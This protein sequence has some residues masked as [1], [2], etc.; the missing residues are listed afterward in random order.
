MT[1]EAG[2][3]GSARLRPRAR[4]ISLIGEELISDEPVALVELVKNSFDADASRVIVKFEGDDPYQPSRIVVQDDGIGMSLDTVLGAWFEPGTIAKRGITSSPGGRP[5]QGAKGIGRFATARLANSLV[6]ESVTSDERLGVYVLLDWGVFDDQSYLDDISVEYETRVIP[7]L[8]RGTRLTLEGLRKS[9]TET[10]Y[11]ALHARLSRLI[12]PFDEVRDFA[13]ELI[14]PAFSDLSGRVAPPELVL[15]PKYELRGRLNEVGEFQGEIRL[16]GQLGR[17]IPLWRIKSRTDAPACG[18]FEVEIRAWDR[19][20]DALVPFAESLSLSV[21]EVRR[22]L[23]AYCGISVYRNGFRVHP[24][25]ESGDD[26]LN[27]DIRSRLSPASRLANNQVI[28]AIRLSREDNPGLRDRSNRE[29]MVHNSEF[30]SLIDWF[31]EILSLLEEYRYRLRPRQATDAQQSEP[32]FEPFDISAAVGRATAELGS[33]HPVTKLLAENER[34]IKGGIERVQ[35]TF[36]RMLLTAGLGQM[37]DVVLHE[38]GSPLGKVNRQLDLLEK[39]L[40]PCLDEPDS[41]AAEMVGAIRSWLEQIHGLRQRLEPQTAGR[42]GRATT[43]KVR[44]EIDDNLGL[45]SAL[46]DRQRIQVSV[47]ESSPDVTVTMSRAALGQIVANLLDNA[48]FW[49][50][51]HRG[52]GKGGRIS[53]GLE[54]LEHGFRILFSDDGPGILVQD[55]IRIFDPYYSTK[56]NGIGLGLY[57]A[58]FLVEPYGRLQYAEECD[59]SGACLDVTFDRGVGR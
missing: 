30:R 17:V 32:L 41:R 49:I 9:W 31:T 58:R 16:D 7:D 38:I 18:P 40:A 23:D 14:V 19:D 59:L 57:I 45:Y 29:G 52:A 34:Q 8:P 46:I 13:I 43:F 10:E 56:P 37:V 12:S 21:S 5:Y 20:R 11:R 51:R 25:G 4:L 22:T 27:L 26:W 24:Y 2:T 42:R 47:V 44:D 1:V 35:A 15:R 53:I 54:S 48:I 3:S 6:L 33:E 50:T 36:S 39:E 55:R 28:G